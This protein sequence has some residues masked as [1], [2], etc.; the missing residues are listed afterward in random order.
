MPTLKEN[1]QSNKAQILYYTGVFLVA[2]LTQVVN[3]LDEVIPKNA[4]YYAMLTGIAS[5]G[6]IY[7]TII[8][9]FIFGRDADLDRVK[10]ERK[11]QGQE[12]NDLRIIN[13][14]YRV[15]NIMQGQLLEENKLKP[16][17]YTPEGKYTIKQ[18]SPNIDIE[19]IIEDDSNN[20]TST[21]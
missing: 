5:L 9:K 10:Q 3:S 21:S 12:N 13:E 8:A 18:T 2:A 14:G 7:F 1:I 20:P 4:W 16:I 6:L 11:E 19:E 15:T 17:I